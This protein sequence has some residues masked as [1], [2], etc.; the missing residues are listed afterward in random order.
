[1]QS[2]SSEKIQDYANETPKL[3][4]EDYLN[5]IIDAYGIVQNRSNKI[6]KRFHCLINASWK[7]N[8]GTLD[9][10]FVYS[11]GT[12]SHRIWTIIKNKN[13]SYTGTA[14]DVIGEAR[15]ISAGNTF[16]WEYVLDIESGGSH[17]KVN[18][19]DW[20]YLMNNKIM[21]NRSKMNKFG[22]LVGEV[23][24]TFIKR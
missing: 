6:I 10:S 8:I 1:M 20:M 13:N 18:F 9:E 23:T 21:I 15:G 17:Y 12:K 14:A 2:C 19:K 22:I 5:G 24:L 3:I 7:G 11:D 4:L 16:Y